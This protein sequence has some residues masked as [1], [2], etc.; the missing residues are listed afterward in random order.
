M[1]PAETLSTERARLVKL[2]YQFTSDRAAAEDLAQE[3]L[4][5]AIRNSHKLHDPSGYPQWLSAIARNVCMR[6][7][8]SK[9]RDVSLNVLVAGG[10]LR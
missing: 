7:H 1:I 3:T 5:E 9:G 8:R 6:W 4:L 10:A 2:C